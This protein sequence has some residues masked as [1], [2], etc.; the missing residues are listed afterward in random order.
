M[1]R[2]RHVEVFQAVMETGSMSRAAEL[3]NLSQ[4]AV[5]RVIAHAESLLGFP[6]FRRVGKKVIPTA[7]ALAL[8]EESKD[9]FARLEAL[10]RTAS[11]LRQGRSGR[12]RVAAIPA[13]CHRLLPDVL[14]AYHRAFPGVQIEVRSLHKGQ[15]VAAL[16]SRDVDVALDFYAVSHPAIEVLGLA[17][18]ELRALYPAS[19][20]SRVEAGEGLAA[21]AELPM[22]TLSGDDP[23]AT[24]MTQAAQQMQQMPPSMIGVQ[25]TQLAEELVGRGLGWTI[26]DFISAQAANGAKVAQAPLVPGQSCPLNALVLRDH[27]QSQQCRALLALIRKHLR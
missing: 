24:A 14:A 12:L 18:G 22:I 1:M 15:M 3:L 23:I 13:L 11:N 21:L 8:F 16:V 27:P 7:E 4:P 26:A 10:R 2:L 25:T 20:R 19:W 6:L 17:Q 5:S 9:I